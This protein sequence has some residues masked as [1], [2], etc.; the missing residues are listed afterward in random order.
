[1]S[2]AILKLLRFPQEMSDRQQSTAGILREFICS[3]STK[4]IVLVRQGFLTAFLD[5]CATLLGQNVCPPEGYS[6]GLVSVELM[7]SLEPPVL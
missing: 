3:C 7:E 4:G 6:T 1:M 5:S 2:T